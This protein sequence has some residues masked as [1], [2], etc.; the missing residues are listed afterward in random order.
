MIPV[1]LLIGLPFIQAIILITLSHFCPKA[2]F[3][4]NR[5]IKTLYRALVGREVRLIFED[6]AALLNEI[7]RS[8]KVEP[9]I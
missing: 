9:A 8:A 1:G 3:P 7:L 4:K 6:Q 5:L 2:M